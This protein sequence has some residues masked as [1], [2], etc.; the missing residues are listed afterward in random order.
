M[1]V[2]LAQTVMGVAVHSEEVAAAI[3]LVASQVATL[4]E[5]SP[6]GVTAVAQ[7]ADKSQG[8]LT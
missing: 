7:A 1:V 4:L 3:R 2:F 5:V 8:K 6:V